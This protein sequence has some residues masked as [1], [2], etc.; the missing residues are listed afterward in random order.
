MELDL[1]RYRLVV[2]P[3]SPIAFSI[4][5]S[6]ELLNFLLKSLPINTYNTGLRKLFAAAM[7]V[8][9]LSPETKMLCSKYSWLISS[10]MNT[11]YG[12]Q[13][14]KKAATSA[15]MTFKGLLDLVILLFRSLRIM[16]E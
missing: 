8:P 6:T 9:T 16:I 1:D 5:E 2:R 14:T 13:Q 15:D 4:F 10:R 11:W 12:S 7:H 3:S